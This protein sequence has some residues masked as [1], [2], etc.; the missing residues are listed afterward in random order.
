MDGLRFGRCWL[1]GL[2][3]HGVFDLDGGINYKLEVVGINS[4][5]P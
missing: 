4:E 1:L 2:G 5:F 3:N